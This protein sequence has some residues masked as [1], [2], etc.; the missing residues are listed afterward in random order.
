MIDEI[1]KVK[2]LI[3]SDISNIVLVEILLDKIG[4][5]LDLKEEFRANLFV[6]IIEAVKNAIIYGNGNDINK[7][8]TLDI[9]YSTQQLIAIVSDCGSG[10][11]YNNLPDPTSPDN[12]EKITGRGLFL[13]KSLA[14]KVEFLNNGSTLR[15][16]FYFN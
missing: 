15:L 4:N 11:D 6:S 9:E 7:N 14:D 1:K 12:L 8:V 10:F 13:I 3:P 5:E 16:I 2:K